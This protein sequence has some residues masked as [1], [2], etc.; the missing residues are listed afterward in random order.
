MHIRYENTFEDYR[1][2]YEFLLRCRGGDSRW[3]HYQA[4]LIPAF[5]G[6]L[7][8]YAAS[9]ER[10]GLMIV[11]LVMTLSYLGPR[12]P[13]GKYM[14]ACSAAHAASQSARVIELLIDGD[15]ITEVIEGMRSTVPWDHVKGYHL[16]RDT[17]FLE[18][19]MGLW[20]I[21]PAS[22]LSGDT[23]EIHEV[24]KCF[25]THHVVDRTSKV[26]GA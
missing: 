2:H 21:I 5:L 25:D 24:A 15:G 17:I 7:G 19:G 13:Y 4:L 9:P 20:A 6:G 1:N 22:K 11:I 12:L 14:R 18:L 10:I 8:I 3:R 26:I 23:T 16:Y